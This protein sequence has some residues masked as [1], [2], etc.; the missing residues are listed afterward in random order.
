MDLTDVIVRIEDC[1]FPIDFLVVNM[2]MT[3]DLDELKL[4]LFI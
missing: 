4:A 2:K 1:Y 3:K